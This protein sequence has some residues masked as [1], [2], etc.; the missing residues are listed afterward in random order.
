[1]VPEEELKKYEFQTFVVGI[2][3]NPP[4]K[5]E[6]KSKIK[7]EITKKFNAK[8]D[9]RNPDIEI[10][11]DPITSE[12]YILPRPLYI[13]GK[14]NKYVK[15]PQSKWP[16]KACRGKGCERCNFT[17]KLYEETVEDLIA[18]PILEIT[19][20]SGTKF[21]G[22]GRED[23]DVLCYGWRE[24]VI[25]VIN[26]KK[27]YIDLKDLERKINEYAKGKV[28]V[29]DLRLSSKQEARRLKSERKNKIYRVFVRVNDFERAREKLGEIEKVFKEIVI[30]QRT[31][32]RVLHRRSD[33][34][35]ERK[36]FYVKL[37]EV[38]E[39]KSEIVLDIKAEAGA[40]I[41]EFVTGDN[42]RTKPSIQ[43]Y[44]GTKLEITE[45]WVIGF[46]G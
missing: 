30:K 16:C 8:Y 14:Y 31:P 20:G 27:R 35:R 32:T 43:E 41:K 44:L 26:P 38:N 37:V 9:P 29:K 19:K 4:N 5:Q 45:M 33:K 7:E 13:Y 40:Y 6:L 15:I 25:E 12:C 11:Y 10:I 34:L 28:E 2:K 21:H 17:G 22:A 3:G 42:G 46:E 24:F 23:I 1:M 18:K 36:I 39:E